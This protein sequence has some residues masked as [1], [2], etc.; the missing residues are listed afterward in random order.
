MF[1]HH[2]IFLRIIC[3]FFVNYYEKV[4]FIHK[5]KLF[6]NDKCIYMTITFNMK[7]VVDSKNIYHLIDN[8]FEIFSYKVLL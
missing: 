5:K 3:F 1:D 2:L 4:I 6:L 7:L 8:S